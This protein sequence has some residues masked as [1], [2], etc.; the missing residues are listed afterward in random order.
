MPV[1]ICKLA[2]GMDSTLSSTLY[3]RRPLVLLHPC[4]IS[5]LCGGK[6]SLG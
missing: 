1:I 3:C 2:V 4:R 5:S 6:N